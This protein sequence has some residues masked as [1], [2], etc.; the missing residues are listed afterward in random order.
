MKRLQTELEEID[1]NEE[2]KAK[3]RRSAKRKAEAIA[4]EET[5]FTNITELMEWY[6]K[7]KGD[8]E[9]NDK[10]DTKTT[11]DDKDKIV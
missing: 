1:S 3:D 4:A 2:L 6:E 10:K 7:N 11:K 8:N 5:G 9:E